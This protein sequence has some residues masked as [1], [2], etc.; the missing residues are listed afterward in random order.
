MDRM[1]AADAAGVT[2]VKSSYSSLVKQAT[3]AQWWILLVVALLIVAAWP[4][5]Q[6]RSLAAKFVNWAVDPSGT[7]PILPDPFAPGEGDDFEAVNIHDLQTRMYDELYEK[8]GWT[9][10]RLQLKVAGDPLTPGTERQL[11]A[12][13][14]VTAAFLVWR[15]GGVK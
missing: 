14:G 10:M 1:R 5:D 7:L 4:S 9:R 3:N 12:A 8:G 13:F 15:M 2:G 11:L 6:D